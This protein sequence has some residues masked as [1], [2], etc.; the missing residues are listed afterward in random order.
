MFDKIKKEN[1]SH[2]LNLGVTEQSIVG[3]AS[4]MA[5]EGFRP[6][7]YSIVPFVLERPFE[8]IKLDIV[9]QDVNVKI[10][11]FWNYPHAGPTHTTKNPERI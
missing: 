8:Q 9:Q 3:L 6:Y 7:I 5:L 1:P 4:G 10:V 11:G 2:L